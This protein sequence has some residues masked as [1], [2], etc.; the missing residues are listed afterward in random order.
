MTTLTKNDKSTLQ[1]LAQEWVDCV[2]ENRRRKSKITQAK[3]KKFLSKFSRKDAA[4]I[5]K[6]YNQYVTTYVKVS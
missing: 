6:L 4:R 2:R 3:V 1:L 5:I